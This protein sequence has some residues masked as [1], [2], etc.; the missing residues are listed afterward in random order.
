MDEYKRFMIALMWTIMMFFALLLTV[1]VSCFTLTGCSSV[2]YVPVETIKHDSIYISKLERDSIHVH[3]SIYLEVKQQADTIIKTKYVQK[4]VYR[5]ALR[6]DTLFI[7]RVDSVKVP[8]PVE[9][10]LSKWESVKMD[11]G[12]IAI[13]GIVMLVI[14]AAL[15]WI[16]KHKRNNI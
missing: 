15:G 5:D 2:R 8:Y 16:I 10:K 9:R 12:G 1:M 3:D 6:V 14:G 7:E 13:G 11:I 4:V